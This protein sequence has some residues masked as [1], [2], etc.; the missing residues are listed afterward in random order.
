MEG[1]RGPEL[2]APPWV[3]AH[4]GNSAHEPENSLAALRR[5]VADGADMVE[6]D[7]QLTA[8]GRFRLFHDRDAE[9]LTGVPG[10]LEA[11]PPER[12]AELRL[13]GRGEPVPTLEDAFAAVPPEMPLN[14]EVKRWVADPRR[15]VDALEAALARRPDLLVS[16][17]DWRLLRDLRERDRRVALAPLAERDGESLL[18]EA[19]GL[20]AWS[21]HAHRRLVG[22]TLLEG[23]RR[24]GRPLLV[25]TVDSI[26]MARALYA[27]GVS[28]VFTTDPGGL[29]RGL[30]ARAGEPGS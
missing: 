12:L 7:V 1:S 26:E 2:P 3:V 9:R 23:A 27:V 19:D 20:A 18:R 4:R 5:A 22:A 24:A 11:M 8:D 15:V 29:R 30:T 6:V 21:V 16:S 28:G 13:G 17:F 25:Y 14:V 10:A